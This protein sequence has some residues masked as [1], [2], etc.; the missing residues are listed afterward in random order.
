MKL[1]TYEI[2]L[3]WKSVQS[4]RTLPLNHA[5]EGSYILLIAI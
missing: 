3:V 4:V 5:P 2:K 1:V